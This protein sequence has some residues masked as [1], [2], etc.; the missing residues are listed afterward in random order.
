MC[1]PERFVGGWDT[2][3]Y[4]FPP[5]AILLSPMLNDLLTSRQT[6]IEI[7][8]KEASTMYGRL[9]LSITPPLSPKQFPGGGE[10]FLGGTT[11]RGRKSSDAPGLSMRRKRGERIFTRPQRP[12]DESSKKRF[13]RTDYVVALWAERHCV[14]MVAGSRLA[15]WKT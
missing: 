15:A 4:Q 12:R 14:R 5:F 9:N 3:E 8:Q 7:F 6:T 1:T 10:Q 2:H 13:G 11:A